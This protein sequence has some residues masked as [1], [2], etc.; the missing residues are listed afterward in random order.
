MRSFLKCHITLMDNKLH[1]RIGKAFVEFHPNF[2]L[3]MTTKIQKPE[4]APAVAKNIVMI[5]FSI[6][7]ISL[8]EQLMS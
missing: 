7:E 3:Y 2:K 4:I 5:D 6:T 8:Q 1:V